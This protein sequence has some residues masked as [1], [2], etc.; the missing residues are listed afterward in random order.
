[1]EEIAKAAMTN[2]DDDIIRTKEGL[3]RIRPL[4]IVPLITQVHV[5]SLSIQIKRVILT[6]E[7]RFCYHS[8][9]RLVSCKRICEL[10]LALPNG[11]RQGYLNFHCEIVFNPL[12]SMKE[13]APMSV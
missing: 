5:F 1:M 9:P 12:I 11:G 13:F 6:I 2:D 3:K 7:V 8:W 4:L 10:S